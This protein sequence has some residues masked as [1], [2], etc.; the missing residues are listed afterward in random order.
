ML[1]HEAAGPGNIFKDVKEMCYRRASAWSFHRPVLLFP[2]TPQIPFGA[3][4]CPCPAVLSYREACLF[5]CHLWLYVYSIVGYLHEGF[6]RYVYFTKHFLIL[7]LASCCN[8]PA[9]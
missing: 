6:P 1:F 7:D 4:V 3:F 8:Q 5:F 9:F 2:V